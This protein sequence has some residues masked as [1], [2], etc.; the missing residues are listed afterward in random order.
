MLELLAWGNSQKEIAYELDMKAHTVDVH[1]KHIKEKAGLQKATELSSLWF[2]FTYHIPVIS[3]PDRIKRAIAAL[4]LGVS[5]AGMINHADML[6]V[7]RG[8][9]SP[10][11]KTVNIRPG[12]SRSRKTEYEFD[13]LLNIN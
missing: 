2:S 6:R 12:T 11:A 5:I 8:T 4:L 7:F 3:I 13:E 1:V 10:S 9:G